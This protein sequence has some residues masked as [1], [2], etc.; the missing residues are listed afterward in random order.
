[1]V[2]PACMLKSKD[3]ISRKGPWGKASSSVRGMGW[4]SSCQGSAEKNKS[5]KQWEM[6]ESDSF[7]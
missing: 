6:S 5:Q 4:G 7:Y 1:M 2:W 3:L